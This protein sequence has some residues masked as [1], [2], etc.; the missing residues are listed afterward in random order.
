MTAFGRQQHFGSAVTFVGNSGLYFASA[1]AHFPTHVH[2]YQ[3]LDSDS[4]DPWSYVWTITELVNDVNN[5]PSSFGI[6]LCV[7][8]RHRIPKLVTS[9]EA[10]RPRNIRFQFWIKYISLRQETR[11][12]FSIR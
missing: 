10:C 7:P 9:C 5:Q 6:S 1:S 11:C 3:R 2:I 4:G 12:E 8:P